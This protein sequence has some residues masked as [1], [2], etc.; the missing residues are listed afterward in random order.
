[1][2]IEAIES[3]HIDPSGKSFLHGT[4][5]GS[6]L[7]SE[8]VPGVMKTPTR[9]PV[10]ASTGTTFDGAAIIEPVPGADVTTAGPIGD[11]ELE[12]QERA[13]LRIPP[14]ELE[15]YQGQFVI[16]CNGKIMDSDSD[17][18][19]LGRRFFS[20]HGDVPAYIT[21]V[22]GPMEFTIRTPFTR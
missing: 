15:R 8:E 11:I 2:N 6:A 5:F 17:L 19:K 21:K 22:G 12:Q 9:L 1:M 13:F 16:S 4:P 18:T 7:A 10:P 3:L 20:E 14:A